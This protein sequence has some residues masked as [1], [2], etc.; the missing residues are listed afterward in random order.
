MCTVQVFVDSPGTKDSSTPPSP[1]Q[2]GITSTKQRSKLQRRLAS[3]LRFGLSNVGEL[4]AQVEELYAQLDVWLG[5][6]IK[7][8]SDATSAVTS[9]MRKAVEAEEKLPKALQLQGGR[10]LLNVNS[11]FII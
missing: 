1:V 4:K 9:I 11:H 10:A 5:A 3:V 7:Q 2:A 6:R 8:E